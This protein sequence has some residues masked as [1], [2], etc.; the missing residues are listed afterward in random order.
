MRLVKFAFL[1]ARLLDAK[2]VAGGLAALVAIAAIVI[3]AEPAGAQQAGAYIPAPFLTTGHLVASC[4]QFC[5]QDGG[6]A[7]AT[8]G[9]N[10][11]TGAQ[12]APAFI[13]NGTTPPS[14][15]LYAPTGGGNGFAG[16]TTTY[17]TAPTV[18][19]GSGDCGTAPSIVGNDNNGRITVGSSTNGGQCTLTFAAA[20]NHAPQ[21][22]AGDEGHNLNLQP[23]PTTTTLVIKAVLTA[24]DTLAYRCTDYD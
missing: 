2:G 16:H 5:L 17:G 23:V 21:C 14:L 3:A 22:V 12:T 10:T 18:A 7:G 19:S 6:G 20:W 1:H 4:G 8:T 24:G 11:F 9:A 15:G 13:P